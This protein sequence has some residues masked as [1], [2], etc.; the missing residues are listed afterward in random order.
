MILIKEN[1]ITGQSTPQQD[2]QKKEE[3]EKIDGIKRELKD[4]IEYKNEDD[5]ISPLYNVYTLLNELGKKLEWPVTSSSHAQ[6]PQMS[7][8]QK[9]SLLFEIKHKT[10]AT[11]AKSLSMSALNKQISFYGLAF[12]FHKLIEFHSYSTST[13][14]LVPLFDT[15]NST[16]PSS[17][18]IVIECCDEPSPILENCLANLV[19]TLELWRKFNQ[20]KEWMTIITKCLNNSKSD[21]IGYY[22]N[23]VADYYNSYLLGLSGTAAAGLGLNWTN[24]AALPL[25]RRLSALAYLFIN[26]KASFKVIISTI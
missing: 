13:L 3:R 25:K 16:S 18:P 10:A 14:I 21:G 8:E 17:K 2:D 23:F 11:D 20:H 26:E 5:A 19:F 4:L 7:I 24:V 15:T 22:K 9:M 12:F 1:E 6:W